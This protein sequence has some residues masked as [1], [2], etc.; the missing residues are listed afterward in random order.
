MGRASKS[1]GSSTSRLGSAVP[2]STTA[3]AAPSHSFE[4]SSEMPGRIRGMKLVGSPTM[5][6]VS[7]SPV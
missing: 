7:M 5:V 3:Y 2:E 1:R 6:D 4:S